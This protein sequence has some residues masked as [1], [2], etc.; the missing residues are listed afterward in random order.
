MVILLFILITLFLLF[1]LFFIIQDMLLNFSDIIYVLSGES[2]RQHKAVEESIQNIF[3]VGT[4]Y[5]F[6]GKYTSHWEVAR[7]EWLNHGIQ[8]NQGRASHSWD[9]TFW[10]ELDIP[11]EGGWDWCQEALRYPTTREGWSGT[12]D[13]TFRGKILERGCFGHMGIC[14]YR[15]EVM[16]ILSV[17]YNHAFSRIE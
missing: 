16:E 9:T 11:C 5:I 15:I 10:C 14:S 8:L 13:L 3:P 4:E 17:S 6:T 2:W 12:F 1:C 7:F